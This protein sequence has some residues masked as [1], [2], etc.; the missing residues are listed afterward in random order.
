MKKTLISLVGACSLTLLVA[1]G[2]D[3]EAAPASATTSAAESS[4]TA[5]ELANPEEGAPLPRT[6]A[7]ACADVVLFL[8]GYQKTLEEAGDTTGTTREALAGEL[9]SSLEAYPEWST[10]SE[11]EQ[12]EVARG[13]NAAATGT[14]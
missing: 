7:Q 3:D 10:M 5:D 11:N 2:S 9:L 6:Y 13:I 12:S 4:S 14:C 1:C 8:D